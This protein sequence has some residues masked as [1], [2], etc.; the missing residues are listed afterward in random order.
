DQTCRGAVRRQ[1]SYAS[2]RG[3]PWGISESAYNVRD[4]HLTYQY[5]A[6]G[7]PDLALKRGLARD[8]VVAPYATALAAMMDA[9]T[10]LSNMATLEKRGA[11]GEYGFRDA[12]DYT[13]P[14]PG[15]KFG[16]V[17]NYMA[18]HIGMS[19][20]ALT[21]V[22]EGD[23]WQE[24]FHADP[25]VR[26]AELLLHERIPRRLVFQPAA[27]VDGGES[28]AEPEIERP[29]VRVYDTADTIQ[30]R[31]ALLGHLPYTIMISNRGSGYSRY[32]GIAVTR[33]R[34]DATTDNTGQFCYIKDVT[35]GHVWSAAYQPVCAPADSYRVSFATDR[36]AFDRVDGNIETR[37]EITVV[38]AD[39]AEVRRI[40][41][42]NNGSTT[43][44]L[45]LTSY[46]EIVLA[47]PDADRAHPAFAN[48]FVQTEWH[49]WCSAILATRRPRSADEQTVWVVHVVAVDG[50]LVEP[51]SCE[52]DRARFLGRGRTTRDPAAL[53]A[54][55][56]GRLSM[57][58]GAVL[59]PIMAIRARIRLEPGESA[60]VAFTTLVTPTRERAWE[61]AD[62]YDDPSASQRALDLA[63]TTA[64]VELR[65]LNI[66]P[67]AAAVYQDVAGHLFDA[68]RALGAADEERLGNRGTQPLLWSIGVSGDWPI[69]LAPID[70]MEGLST[71]RQLLT[72]HR[73]WRRRGMQVD[74]VVLDTHPPTYQ[75]EVRD[76]ITATVLA[77]TEGGGLDH[78]GGVFVR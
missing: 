5:R 28:L 27:L 7:V 63:W 1:I 44:E 35:N 15:E 65:E 78:P 60:T 29:A 10:A 71:L 69:L 34:A 22:L 50:E 55:A 45:E 46:G 17:R 62:R 20:V 13:R 56:D 57:T 16:I 25:L 52:P 19:I 48:L 36:V 54:S 40:T 12:L 42:T 3:V 77:S 72:A 68:N 8:L 61:M 76:R 43:H 9:S 38:P 32:E 58:V 24:R 21:N 73:Y 41:V 14:G 66:P 6:F 51:V 18:H 74:L 70:S 47:P 75:K 2:E 67:A 23:C 59:D 53:D 33:W 37:T 26:S 39:A 11:L 30:P 49:E 64:Q 4:R 31:I